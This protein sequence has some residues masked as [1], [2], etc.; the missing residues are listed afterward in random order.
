MN[1]NPNYTYLKQQVPEQRVTL[2]Q[3][4]TRSGKT[5]SVVYYLIYLC[6]TNDNAGLEIDL[7]RDT[8]TALK[9][10]AWKDFKTVLLKH[11]LY[12]EANHNKTDHIYTLA[13]N[14]IS[15]YGADNPHKIHGR[16]RDILWVNEAHQFPQETVDQLFPRTRHRIICD[17]NP[18]IGHDHWL[19]PLIE[20]YPP[21]ITTYRDNPHLTAS[22]IAEIESR[23]EQRYWWKVYGSG[24]R[25]AR[26]GV[27][28]TNWQL[29]EFDES[30][31]YCYGLD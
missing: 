19:D 30:L 11:S 21:I 12:D 17:Y 16:S 1:A 26:E 7:V 28:F 2:L 10:T 20:A 4:G 14:H 5:F 27:I 13:G 15:Y 18:A 23:K 22:Q 3:G 6:T 9:A 29:G 31:P 8:F 25:A 24:E